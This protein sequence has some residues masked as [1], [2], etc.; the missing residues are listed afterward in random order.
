M[1]DRG[2]ATLAVT[3]DGPAAAMVPR[4]L[5]GDV[6]APIEAAAALASVASILVL[7]PIV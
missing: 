6:A 2:L 1:Q 3:A 4:R 7:A 5:E